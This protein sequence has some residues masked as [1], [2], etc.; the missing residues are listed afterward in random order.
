MPRDYYTGTHREALDK[1][2]DA[3]RTGAISDDCI[4]APG[5]GRDKDGYARIRF[6]DSQPRAHNYV[7]RRAVGDPPPGKSM[8]CHT[9]RTKDCVSPRHLYWGDAGDNAADRDRDGTTARGE[10][11][12]QVH[13]ARGE[14]C[15]MSGLTDDGVREIRRLYA[16]GEYTQQALADMYGVAQ[17]TVSDIIHR[18]LWTH[19]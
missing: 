1:I 12:R 4:H 3:Y 14:A 5:A 7:L 19:I 16:T 9:C 6:G 10:A 18:K 13:R 8:A 2:A 15:S 17:S 11:V